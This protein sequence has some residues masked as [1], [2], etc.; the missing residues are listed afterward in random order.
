MVT[1]K[2]GSGWEF[3]MRLLGKRHR[4]GRFRTKAEA[5]AA[6]KL[7]REELLSG[8][9][10]VTMQEAYEKYLASKK[11]AT[12]T[13]EDYEKF[14]SRDIAK[15]LAH[16]YVEEV[17]TEAIDTVKSALPKDLGPKSINQ[18]LILIRAVLRFAWK[19]ELLAHP[20][21]VPMEKL[22]RR[23]PQ[24]YSLRERDD[25][26][27]GMFE[28]HPQWYLFFYVTVR[29]GLR[30]GELYGIEHRHF[31]REQGVLR[32]DQAV[33]RGTKERDAELKLRKGNDTLVLHVTDDVFDVYEWHCRR[34]FAG[35]RLVFSPADTIP[36][37]LDS[38]KYP[39]KD[40]QRAKK[41]RQLSHH[42][43]GRHSVGSQAIAAGVHMKAVQRQLGHKSEAS[44][45]KYAHARQDA[46]KEI[47]E[48]LRLEK[49]PHERELN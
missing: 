3:D 47:V 16:L 10:K 42:T 38:H 15:H 21:W 23:D 32:I 7:K 12:V 43:V 46:Q 48:K 29:L 20:P 25:L 22:E 11:F 33:E 34:G 19:R 5:A 27:Q 41:L 24:W 14:W 30:R 9:R 35:K 28:M 36:R 26:L 45:H 17:R 39:L 44:T 2:R 8:K 1:R 37:Y 31:Q 18:R 49:A 13:R 6:E 40:V 4:K